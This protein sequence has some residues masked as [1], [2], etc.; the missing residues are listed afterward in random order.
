MKRPTRSN[1]IPIRKAKRIGPVPAVSR[2]VRFSRH[3]HFSRNE[4]DAVQ[5][6]LRESSEGYIYDDSEK[7]YFQ[8]DVV[9]FDRAKPAQQT[10]VAMPE[11]NWTMLSAARRKAEDTSRRREKP[12]CKGSR[13]FLHCDRDIA[14]TK[15]FI[16]QRSHGICP[17]VRRSKIPQLPNVTLKRGEKIVNEGEIDHRTDA[18]EDRGRSKLQQS[19]R[20]S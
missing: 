17:S 13:R 5:S 2:S 19:Q 4:L 9:V 15:H 10:T 20:G 6:A 1:R 16:R 18:F 8:N 12:F 14:G 3:A 11:S 7:Q